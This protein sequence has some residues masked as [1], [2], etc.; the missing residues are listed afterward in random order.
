MMRQRHATRAKFPGCVRQ[1]IMT[2]RAR[3]HF[4][5]ELVFLRKL[6][7]VGAFGKATQ[8]KLFRGAL[9]EM[10]IRIRRPATQTMIEVRDNEFPTMNCRKLVQHAQQHHRIQ[11]TRHRYENA[12]AILEQAMAGNVLIDTTEQLNRANVFSRSQLSPFAN[13]LQCVGCIISNLLVLVLQ[14]PQ[15]L[16]H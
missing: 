8:P 9:H 2:Q 12:L 1:K 16:W 4:H 11:S 13:G 5:R 15:N 14:Q 6:F 7:H 3:G 10:L